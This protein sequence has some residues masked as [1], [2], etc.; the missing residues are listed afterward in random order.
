MKQQGHAN[1]MTCVSYSPDGQLLATGGED[2]K[3]KLWNVLSGF[4]FVT[5]QEH[6]AAITGV[7]FS[8]NR[9]FVVSSS[10]DGTVRAYD[11][12][13]YRNFRT[14]TSPRP[15]QLSC[16]AVDSNGEFVAAGGQ[17]IFEIFLWSIKLG[18]LLEILS[19]HEGPV[20]SLA[21]SPVSTS[22][23]LA[24]VSWDKTLRLWNA[25][26]KASAH[27][28]IELT[29]DGLSVAYKPD[30]LDVAV[31]SLDGNIQIYN[32]KTATQVASIEGRNDLGSGRSETD[33]VTAKKSLQA[34]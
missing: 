32:V 4:C 25:I 9:K 18:R 1:N 15:V 34:K 22:T 23:A 24:S 8:G 30:G 29:S 3:V 21:F 12:I 27:E 11:V 20:W 31:A 33:L 26:E 16:V 2:G 6:S 28:T 13:R 17:D 5:F 14:F 19:G 7:Q 10:L